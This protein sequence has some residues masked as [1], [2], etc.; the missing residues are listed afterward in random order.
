MVSLARK[1]LKVTFEGHAIFA[2]V[3]KMKQKV[4]Q[5]SGRIQR[6]T[7]MTEQWNN[8]DAKLGRIKGR[9]GK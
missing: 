2:K 4:L 3:K 5:V 6:W 1:N 7:S 9:N 8:K